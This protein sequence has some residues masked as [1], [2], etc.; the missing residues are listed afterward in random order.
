[1]KKVI[2]LLL[3]IITSC[4]QGEKTGTKKIFLEPFRDQLSYDWQL[5]AIKNNL[6]KDS[7]LSNDIQF[8]NDS[9]LKGKFKLD[10]SK[11]EAEYIKKKCLPF[12]L[13]KKMLSE[14]YNED[15]NNLGDINGDKKDDFV[16]VLHGLNYCE[17]TDSYY[18]T[19]NNIPRILTDS[20]CCHTSSIINIGD[21]D[22]DGKCEI[23]QYYSSC[24]SRYKAITIYSLKNN[25]WKEIKTFSFV[26]NNKYLI[27]RDFK[28]LFKKTSKNNLEYYEIN[29]IDLYDKMI[30]SWEKTTIE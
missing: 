19:D 22:E 14:L 1:M 18:F 9:I 28:K 15:F 3:L 6:S 26:L 29:D 2:I 7:I 12:K 25:Q 30:A 10:I 13:S 27:P 11:Y 5:I 23:A 8:I 24:V 16:F 4:N 20:N 21:I 17:E